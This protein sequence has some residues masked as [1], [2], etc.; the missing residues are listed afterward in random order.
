MENDVFRA[1]QGLQR[2]KD[3]ILAALAEDLNRD[4]VWD[5]VLLD[6][7]AAKIKLDLRRRR[8]TNFD[9]LETNTDKHVEVFDFFIHAHGLS[10]RLIAVAQIHAAPDRSGGKSP[11]RPLA[12]RKINLGKGLVFGDGRILHR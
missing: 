10:E 7:A 5:S 11:V 6:E 8:K 9:F 1:G 2:A 3:E 4:I 12:V